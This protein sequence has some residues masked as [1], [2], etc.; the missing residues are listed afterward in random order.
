M[1]GRV[2]ERDDI[3]R[4]PD[5]TQVRHRQKATVYY[6]DG[7]IVERII[8]TALIYSQYGEPSRKAYFRESFHDAAINIFLA[9][10][11]IEVARH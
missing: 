2:F 4:W 8:F 6:P 10:S 9:G 1:R 11:K 5:G 7:T 3:D